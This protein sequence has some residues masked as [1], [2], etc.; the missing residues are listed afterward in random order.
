MNNIEYILQQFKNLT[1]IPS[2]SGYTKEVSDYLITTLKD[3]GYNPKRKPP[4]ITTPYWINKIDNT[5]ANIKYIDL[6][7]LWK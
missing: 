5:S 7:G 6:R 1:A 4:A 2:P 3:M